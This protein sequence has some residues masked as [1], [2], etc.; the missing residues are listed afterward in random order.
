M[1]S[2]AHC[3]ITHFWE[4]MRTDESIHSALRCACTTAMLFHEHEAEDV[5]HKYFF[6]AIVGT[7]HL[8]VS[9]VLYSVG[10]MWHKQDIGISGDG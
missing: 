3:V 2:C 9:T 7:L 4:A 1:V 5:S 6:V 8:T 10:E